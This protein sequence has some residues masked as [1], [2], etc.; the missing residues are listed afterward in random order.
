[1]PMAWVA[2]GAPGRLGP[3]VLG[4]ASQGQTRS[5]DPGIRVHR[6]PSGGP[7]RPGYCRVPVIAGA[8]PPSTCAMVDEGDKGQ[9]GPT[10]LGQAQD[11]RDLEAELRELSNKLAALGRSL[12][13]ERGRSLAAGGALR[14]LEIAVGG[15]QARM[16]GACR[17]RDRACERL[18]QQQEAEH[19]LWAE[20]EAA[21]R[22][23]A[24][25]ELRAQEAE[26]ARRAREAELERLRQAH[27]GGRG[28]WGRV[29]GGPARRRCVRPSMPG[30]G[31]NRSAMTSLPECP[32]PPAPRAGCPPRGCRRRWPSGGSSTSSCAC[33]CT[34]ASSRCRSCGWRWRPRG[35]GRGRRVTPWPGWSGSS[36]R[37]GGGCSTHGCP[38]A[39]PSPPCAP[40]ASTCR[41]CCTERPGRGRRCRG[42]A[43]WP[44]GACGR[45]CWRPRSSGCGDSA[46][47]C[48]RSPCSRT[49]RGWGSAWPRWPRGR[50]RRWPRGGSCAGRSRPRGTGP[51]WPRDRW[52]RCAPASGV[53]R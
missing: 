42:R 19:V 32:A 12:V 6:E 27:G 51:R 40:A 28:L 23:R 39:A 18:R 52:P 50:G 13:V 30:G 25:A 26:S 8:P 44:G 43:G 53:T 36:G 37:C 11:R 7:R 38:P 9:R 14:A 17:A 49:V 45:C 48:R 21:R 31:R 22:A 2:P 34:S 1:M 29:R 46:T 3:T 16:G 41:S 47:A 10:R 24:E 35:R 20:L 5:R 33:G 15:A 4:S